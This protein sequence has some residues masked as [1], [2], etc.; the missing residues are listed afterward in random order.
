MANSY[1]EIGGE[2]G[3]KRISLGFMAGLEKNMTC[4][5]EVEFYFLWLAL[6]EDEE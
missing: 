4:L 2:R 3:V 1:T 5:G 6:G